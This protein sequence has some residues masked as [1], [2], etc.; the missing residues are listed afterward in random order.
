MSTKFFLDYA[1]RELEDF[2]TF[3]SAFQK[4]CEL[5]ETEE[6]G[7]V[8]QWKY[9][10]LFKWLNHSTFSSAGKKSN[11]VV[12]VEY[13]NEYTHHYYISAGGNNYSIAIVTGCG[14]EMWFMKLSEK[15]FDEIFPKVEFASI[16]LYNEIY[17]LR[18]PELKENVERLQKQYDEEQAKIKAV[19]TK[20][21]SV[22]CANALMA[23]FELKLDEASEKKVQE[24]RDELDELK[25]PGGLIRKMQ[26][27]Y[28]S[29]Y[30]EEDMQ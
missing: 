18:L 17:K 5:A 23:V 21:K 2:K 7:I 22:D 26:K 14:T 10:E 8:Q 1:K 29:S 13:D 11:L 15:E 30:D 25:D 28:D 27:I 16:A 3:P 9:P 20:L 6:K 19:E 24:W 12:P 4:L